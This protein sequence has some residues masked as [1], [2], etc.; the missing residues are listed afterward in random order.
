ME[1]FFDE[2]G[3]QETLMQF[4]E[5]DR[6]LLGIPEN[7]SRLQKEYYKSL[8]E[9]V[10]PFV[11][12]PVKFWLDREEMHSSGKTSFIVMKQR[13]FLLYKIIESRGNLTY[14]LERPGEA[15]IQFETTF[16]K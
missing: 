6:A 11:S 4:P 10:N 12:T 5:E 13:D 3:I 14:I 15:S 8:D 2:E 16:E 9:G 7:Y 1:V